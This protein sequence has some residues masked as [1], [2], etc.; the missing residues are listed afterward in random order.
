MCVN[1]DQN[2]DLKQQYVFRS[3]LQELFLG[4]F[5]GGPSMGLILEAPAAMGALCV[6]SVLNSC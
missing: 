1:K 4:L 6:V 2:Y 3:D 5:Y